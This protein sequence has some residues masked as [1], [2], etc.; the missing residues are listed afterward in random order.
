MTL[1]ERQS[2]M[3][4]RQGY[5]PY[6]IIVR[7]RPVKHKKK[8]NHVPKRMPVE[9]NVAYPIRRR[10]NVTNSALRSEAYNDASELVSGIYLIGSS[11]FGWYKIGQ[12]QQLSK[13]I[14]NYRS[15]PFLIDVRHTWQ[16]SEDKVRAIEKELHEHF[17]ARRT[18]ANDAYSEWYELS[19]FD[20]ARLHEMLTHFEPLLTT[21]ASSCCVR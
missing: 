1:E 18:N 9:G 4:A 5:T 10:L 7:G 11:E 2:E 19:Q 13:R 6:T 14:V 15:L 8:A 21:Q 17:K 16:V 20:I 12:S 3:R